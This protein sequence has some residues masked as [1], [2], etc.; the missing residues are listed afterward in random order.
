MEQRNGSLR[1]DLIKWAREEQQLTMRWVADH[2]GPC[3]GY[4]SE[5]ENQKK[6]EVRSEILSAWIRAINVTE[7]FVRGHVPRYLV[8]PD[9]C[10]GMAAD[11]G[12]LIAS[13]QAGP[14]DWTALTALERARET[15]CLISRESRQLPR[16]VL[17]H[18][19]GLSLESLDAIMA[20]S[21]PV[22]KDLMLALVALT[23]LPESFFTHGI[24]PVDAD[25]ADYREYQGALAL[26]RSLRL[27]PVQLEA[28]IRQNLS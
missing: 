22:V 13:G 16:V 28:L 18:V 7:P 3:L 20:G 21:L 25:E 8:D 11:V 2:G 9:R 19:L 5:V 10:Q 15:L 1:G 17:G 27:S 12:R 24:L 26:A 14:R 23:G 4:Q 6:A